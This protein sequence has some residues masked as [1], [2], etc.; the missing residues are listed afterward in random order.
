MKKEK[1]KITRALHRVS[2]R[3]MSE[4]QSA[5][6][7]Q[8][9]GFSWHQTETFAGKFARSERLLTMLREHIIFNVKWV[10]VYKMSEVFSE[11]VL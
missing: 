1:R 10:K 6:R 9:L 7:M 3:T 8:F 11:I 5:S 4:S 2:P